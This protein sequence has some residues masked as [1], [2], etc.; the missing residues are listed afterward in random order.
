VIQN[1]SLYNLLS[2]LVLLRWKNCRNWLCRAHF[3]ARPWF[4]DLGSRTFQS[5]VEASNGTFGGKNFM[6]V[7][8]IPLVIFYIPKSF[9]QCENHLNWRSYVKV[10]PPPSWLTVLTTMVR[11]GCHGNPITQ[12]YGVIYLQNF[13]KSIE[14]PKP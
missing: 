11:S 14:D 4:D 5:C 6:R 8:P 10:V 12:T 1:G 2:M 7:A 3:R 9:Q 13:K